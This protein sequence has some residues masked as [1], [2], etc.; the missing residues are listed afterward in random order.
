MHLSCI[1]TVYTLYIYIY[2]VFPLGVFFA[3]A[4]KDFVVPGRCTR[5]MPAVGVNING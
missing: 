4:G 2:T 3:A 1:Y 5:G